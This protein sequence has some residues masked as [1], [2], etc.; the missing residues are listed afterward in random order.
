DRISESETRLRA[1]AQMVQGPTGA[2]WIDA[3]VYPWSVIARRP[4]VAA[5]RERLDAAYTR[6][7]EAA[8][9]NLSGLPWRAARSVR[10]QPDPRIAV[11]RARPT[12]PPAT[13]PAT[14]RS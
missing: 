13:I 14:R 4:E 5:A 10:R 11:N 6:E 3:R 1:F 12:L 7:R 8:R 2:M 9:A